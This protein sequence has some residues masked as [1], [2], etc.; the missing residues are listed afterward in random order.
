MEHEDFNLLDDVVVTLENDGALYTWF[1]KFG[2]DH[3][4]KG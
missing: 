2:K 1:C 3:L 4:K